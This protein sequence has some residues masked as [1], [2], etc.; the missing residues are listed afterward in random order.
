MSCRVHL[1]CRCLLSPTSSLFSS[2]S[3]VKKV[4]HGWWSFPPH[5]H[6]FSIFPT[7]PFCSASPCVPGVCGC[8]H[9]GLTKKNLETRKTIGR[10]KKRS[11]TSR[12]VQCFSSQDG[13]CSFFSRTKEKIPLHIEKGS[14]W[15]SLW[16]ILTRFFR[17]HCCFVLV[18]LLNNSSTSVWH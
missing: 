12:Y 15:F 4:F 14:N 5:R 17:C 18:H 1:H 2:T 11:E 16:R 9:V 10:G 6:V 7:R 8:P 3:V 13:R